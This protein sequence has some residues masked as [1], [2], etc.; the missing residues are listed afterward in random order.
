[1]TKSQ[2]TIR[3]YFAPYT[4]FPNS[5][6]PPPATQP[7]GDPPMAKLGNRAMRNLS[8]AGWQA[9]KFT[10]RQGSSWPISN[11]RSPIT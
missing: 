10:G 6:P 7:K 5:R 4:L 8:S 2:T 11:G 9:A 1:M 3:A